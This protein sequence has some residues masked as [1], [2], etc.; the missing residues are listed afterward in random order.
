M[1]RF[2]DLSN[3]L[4]LGI[5]EEVLP[6]DIVSVSLTSKRIHQLAVA[7]LEEHRMLQQR[8]T[9][10]QNM[11]EHKPNNWHD[12]GGLLANPLCKIMI[13][14]RIGHYVKNIDLSFCTFSLRDGWKPDAVFEEEVTTSTT[15]LKQCSKTNMEIIEEA[16]RAVEIIPKEEVNDWLQ[17]IRS[18]NEN[19]LVALLFLYAPKLQMLK[20]ID[21]FRRSELSYLLKMVQRVADQMHT[22][23]SHQ[24]QL[25][26]VEICFA[27]GWK[28]LDFVKAF[29]SLPSLASI[30]TELLFVDGRTH[31]VSSAIL[32][33]PSN[34]TEM[35]FRNGLLPRKV[36]TEL[37]HG[38]TNLKS[39][40]YHFRHLWREGDYKPPFE[41]FALL[42]CLKTTASH[43]LEHLELGAEEIETSSL[44]P[45]RDFQ[46]LQNI[47]IR[48]SLSFAVEGKIASLAGV[49]PVSLERLAMFW[50]EK[51]L[52]EGAKTVAEA[53]VA[54][55]RESVTQ[56]PHLQKLAL[57]TGDQEEMDA[58]FDVFASD[59]TAQ[60]NPRLS[61]NFRGDRGKGD[62]FAG[63]ENVCTCGNNCFGMNLTY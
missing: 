42:N 54:L 7:R 46:S 1:A 44:A 10:F 34:V 12:P 32:P 27:E 22:T 55:V 63:V 3:E 45:L 23:K 8:Y 11:I 21:P 2:N 58:L 14:A 29:M 17:Q 40:S 53:F 47:E 15:R 51:A 38:V 6:E 30:K 48:T 56:L 37:L 28:S 33:W 60:I 39:F 43:T 62:I 41:C 36:M 4:V 25:K 26:N 5:L 20:F 9:N 52:V 59:E 18:G 24:S 50:R 16:V 19:P 35:S 31:E 57:Y 61:F 49:L 13:D